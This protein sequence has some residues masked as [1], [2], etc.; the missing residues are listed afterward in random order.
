MANTTNYNMPKP[1]TLTNIGGWMT[2]WA[3]NLDTIDTELHKHE[4]THFKWREVHTVAQGANTITLTNPYVA[5]DVL[6]VKET[7]YGTSWFSPTHFSISGSTLTFTSAM[8]E[9]LTFEI[10]NLDQGVV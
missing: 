4:V 1:D 8:A 6:I 5:G 2:D 3:N 9:E 7:K 10:L